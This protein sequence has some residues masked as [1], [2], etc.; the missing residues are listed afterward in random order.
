MLS[1]CAHYISLSL[2][3]GNE[4]PVDELAL[5]S[6]DIHALE[7]VLVIPEADRL[8]QLLIRRGV[9]WPGRHW[10]F[11]NHCCRGAAEKGCDGR[12]LLGRGRRDQ[13][14]QRCCRLWDNFFY[15]FDHC[16]FGRH[17]ISLRA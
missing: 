16:F 2:R 8:V 7:P 10:L 4:L 13:L 6:V 5:L 9:Y 3:L 11:F 1:E 17:V 14:D 12:A 15:D